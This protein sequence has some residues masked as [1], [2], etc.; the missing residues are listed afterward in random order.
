VNGTNCVE[1]DPAFLDG[2]ENLQA[3]LSG[4]AGEV[5]LIN[6]DLDV[7][8]SDQFSL[9]M[10]NRLGEWLTSVTLARVETKNGFVFTLG[11][12]YPDGGF[13]ENRS[14]PWTL[15]PTGIAGS[16]L[17]GNSGI[18]SV[19][20][21]VLLSAEKPFSQE[22]R[23]GTTVSYT[24]TDAEQNSDIFN[25]VRYAF[26][27]VHIDEYPFT[28]SNAVPKHRL[29]ATGT[30]SIPWGMRFAA[31]L[32]LASPIPHLVTS[33]LAAP[34]VFDN[35][36]PCTAIAY[37]ASDT[38]GYQ[39]LDLQLTKEFEFGDLGAMYLRLDAINVTNHEN[40]IDYI[41]VTGPDGLVTGG[42]YNRAGNITSVPRTVRMTF[43]VRF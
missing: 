23:W 30:M 5:N 8:Y 22:A 9:G 18:E 33:C 3:L 41:D 7:P 38:I 2:V 28:I 17:I 20:N 39:S 4:V 16:M 6:N 42:G 1:F 24:F 12:R 29:V 10:R 35:G 40:F 37:A 36:A 14:Q 21:Q 43:G 19:T 25:N 11:N 31:K 34:A 27:Q 15:G 13:W 26:D 32:T